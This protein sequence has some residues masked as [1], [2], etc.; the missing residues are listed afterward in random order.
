MLWFRRNKRLNLVRGANLRRHFGLTDVSMRQRTLTWTMR[1]S[2][3]FFFFSGSPSGSRAV[4][5]EAVCLILGRYR[6]SYKVFSDLL[7][8]Q[9]TKQQNNGPYLENNRAAWYQGL[10]KLEVVKSCGATLILSRISQR[11]Q[12]SVASNWFTWH[13]LQIQVNQKIS[14]SVWSFEKRENWLSFCKVSWKLWLCL[15][16]LLCVRV[17]CNPYLTDSRY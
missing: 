3:F 1:F 12:P 11:I 10:M 17:F 7:R 5:G 13:D 15:A 4:F 8:K 6:S 14:F 2:I 16:N 9:Y